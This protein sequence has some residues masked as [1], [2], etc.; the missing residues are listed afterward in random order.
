MK[1]CQNQWKSTQ[2]GENQPKPTKKS[3]KQIKFHEIQ[4]TRSPKNL[5]KWKPQNPKKEK[6]KKHKPP[7]HKNLKSKNLKFLKFQNLQF[8]KSKFKTSKFQI[9]KL[10]T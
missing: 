6:L 1:I 9:Q 7:K 5:K 8:K 4:K 2:I 10:Q 3:Q